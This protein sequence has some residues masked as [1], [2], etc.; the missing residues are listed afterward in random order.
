MLYL[1]IH[2]GEMKLIHVNERAVDDTT[3]HKATMLNMIAL[4][5]AWETLY[6]HEGLMWL[7]T[8]FASVMTSSNGTFSA[9]LAICAGN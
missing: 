5:T 7:L 2:A 4:H 6:A 8:E 1:L 9:L 3:K